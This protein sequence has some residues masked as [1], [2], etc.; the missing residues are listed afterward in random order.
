M[1]DFRNLKIWIQGIDL[2]AKV[3]ELTKQLPR[4]EMFNLRNQMTRAAVSISSNIAEGCSRS[5]G[6]EYSRFL[7]ISLGSTFELE[8]DFILTEKL[9][10]IRSME[11]RAFLAG[12]HKEQK[13]IN[14]LITKIRRSQ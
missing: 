3:Y 8:T 13:M 7:E 11:V 10:F 5:S 4:E 14:V 12:L 2:A 9:Q 1:R 6:R